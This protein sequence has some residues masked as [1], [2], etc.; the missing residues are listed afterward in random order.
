MRLI[1][2]MSISSTSNAKISVICSTYNSA[3]WIQAYLESLNAQFLEEFEVLII[4][5]ASTDGSLDTIKKFPFREGISVRVLEQSTRISVTESMNIGVKEVSGDFIVIYSVDDYLFP[6]ALLTYSKYLMAN[7]SVDF[8]YS[9]FFLHET[10]YPYKLTGIRVWP[11]HSHA[12]LLKFCYGGPFPCIR[13]ASLVKAGDFN[14]KYRS[15]ADYDMWLRLSKN[16]C[17]FLRLNEVIGSFCYRPD[18]VSNQNL[19]SAQLED[20]EIQANNA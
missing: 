7:P 20:V 10:V 6:A 1:E 11:E 2:R 18:S 12:T 13:K 9:H 3:F 17:I 16:G 19:A 8:I 5:A 14:L 4:D 15:S